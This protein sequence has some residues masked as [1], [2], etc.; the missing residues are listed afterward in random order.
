MIYA[1][2]EKKNKKKKKKKKKS[3]TQHIFPALLKKLMKDGRERRKAEMEIMC[4]EGGGE[5][6][7]K[8]KRQRR[9]DRWV[10]RRGKGGWGKV[11]G[12]CGVVGLWGWNG[13]ASSTSNRE[14][15][16]ST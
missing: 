7:M 16:P 1:G 11:G 14:I 2:Q 3:I 10:G 15:R 13:K 4:K 12:G 6:G 8:G 9:R 5:G